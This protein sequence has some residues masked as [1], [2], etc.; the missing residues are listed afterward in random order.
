MG[1][2]WKFY[3]IRQYLRWWFKIYLDSLM[4]YSC[5]QRDRYVN[6]NMYVLRSIRNSTRQWE[7]LISV[8]K[9]NIS[10]LCSVNCILYSVYIVYSEHRTVCTLYIVHCIMYRVY[11][12][13]CTKCKLYSVHSIDCI[14]CTLSFVHSI[15]CIL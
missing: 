14:Q 15:H 8:L 7:W 2:W 9:K 10:L 6:R 13:D 12:E 3:K 1:F 4:Y 11:I 5:T